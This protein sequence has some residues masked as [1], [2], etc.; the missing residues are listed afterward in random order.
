LCPILRAA[1]AAATVPAEIEPAALTAAV[2]RCAR[3]EPLPPIVPLPPRP[4]ST[5]GSV[6]LSSLTP[7]ETRVFQLIGEGESPR[8]IAARLGVSPKTVESHRANIKAKLDIRSAK[9]FN[10]IARACSLWHES[11]IDYVI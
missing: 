8:D 2:V 9:A 10:S 5:A 6:D 7:C 4:D 11:G 1:G 3:G